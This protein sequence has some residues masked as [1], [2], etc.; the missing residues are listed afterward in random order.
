MLATHTPLPDIATGP[1][2]FAG[3]EAC[4]T[5]ALLASLRVLRSARPLLI[6]DG[7]NAFDPF[8]IADLAQRAG[9]APRS[10]LDQIR[11]SRVFTCHQLEALLRGRLDEAVR[12]F[13]AGAVFFSGPL[14]P[15]L[16]E[17]VPAREARRIF[18]LFPAVLRALATARI[19][20]VCGCPPPVAVAG[21]EQL[22]PA[23]CA[24]APWVFEVRRERAGSRQAGPHAE[25]VIVTC[26]KP[27]ARSW[28]WEPQIGLFAPR[29]WW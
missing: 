11:I 17:D 9:M 3:E 27:R 15:L 28:I 25:R 21:R 8:L 18:G 22:F 24:L 20:T 10:L 7:A 14:D 4:L 16:D 2:V 29:R 5:V 23:L 1:A 12:S 13:G 6:V 26:R 19:L